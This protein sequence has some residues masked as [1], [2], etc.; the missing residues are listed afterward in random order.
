MLYLSSVYL[1]HCQIILLADGHDAKILLIE[2]GRRHRTKIFRN[3]IMNVPV[4]LYIYFQDETGHN[5]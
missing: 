4:S 1:L 3:E 2:V 5:E